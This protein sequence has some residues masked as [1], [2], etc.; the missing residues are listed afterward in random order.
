[1]LNIIPE[2]QKIKL[3]NGKL[4]ICPEFKI[5]ASTANLSAVEKL[6]PFLQSTLGYVLKVENIE[7]NDELWIAKSLPD[8][9]IPAPRQGYKLDISDKIKV[10]SSDTTGIFY[11][12]ITLL[13]IMEDN[14]ELPRL[15]V[16]DAP[17]LARRM[18]HWDLKGLMPS[19]EYLKASINKLAYY[20]VNAILV[21]YEDKFT[22][23]KHPILKNKNALNKS[24]VK[25]L[26]G[27]AKNNFI[28]LIPLV[29]CL[30]HAEYVLRHPEYSYVAE[31]DSGCQQYCPSNE[32][33]FELFKGFI[34]EILPFHDSKFIHVGGDETRQLGECPACNSRVKEIGKI[35]LYF[36]YIKKVCD[37]I[38]SLDRIPVIWDDMLT[39]NFRIDLMKKLPRQTVIC[40]WNYFCNKPDTEY[41][42]G[43]D[44]IR[45]FSQYWL[46]K[47]YGSYNERKSHFEALQEFSGPLEKGESAC[48]E[49]LDV[50]KQ[51][52]L[53]KYLNN[54]NFP[55]SFDA[56]Y[57]V[58][59]VKES[60]L[61]YWGAGSAHCSKDGNFMPDFTNRLTNLK[62]WTDYLQD[63]N[64]GAIVATAW[65]KG[66][67]LKPPNAPV[68]THWYSSVAMAE[69]GWSGRRCSEQR[70]DEKF[71]SR[72]F[73]MNDSKLTDALSLCSSSAGKL[74]VFINKRISGLA[75][76]NKKNKLEFEAI[77]AGAALAEME[78]LVM[79][80]MDFCYKYIYQL[81]SKQVHKSTIK[82]LVFYL[83][84]AEQAMVN[85]PI[86]SRKHLIKY[87]SIDEVDEY[88]NSI[89][90]TLAF[91]LNN[92]KSLIMQ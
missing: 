25:E 67:T 28:E 5:Y 64:G 32:K 33:T 66:G 42:C 90:T 84:R 65:S 44:H 16:V 57:L 78:H 31:S 81:N 17:E 56:F 91:Q 50:K 87:M 29:Q 73:G 40:C 83:N 86:A 34:D 38:V 72:F 36:E 30:G 60:G 37:Y 43:P 62:T 39:H 59:Q 63:N 15:S 41:F 58:E 61:S 80:S 10:T 27:L 55:R 11:G 7:N 26:Q 70:F 4:K 53:K 85:P 48:W 76:E 69:W 71:C 51:N 79:S 47:N 23:E 14:S 3:R 75:E 21:E 92:L 1:M 89:I 12:I 82:R 77:A 2:P 19:F 45:P 20:K 8:E 52:K 24:Q 74:S 22:F 35:G 88:L 9:S 46:K 13:Q 18:V 6:N 68:A 49:M 54:K